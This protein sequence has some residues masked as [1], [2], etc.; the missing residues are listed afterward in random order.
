[1]SSQPIIRLK[2]VS[3][4]F[5]TDGGDPVEVLCDVDLEIHPGEKASLIGLSGSGK[6]TLL[7]I[8]AGLLRPDTGT[9]EFEGVQMSDLDETARARLRAERIGIALQSDN[10][11]PFLSA[12]ENVELALGFGSRL[13]RRQARLRALEL[14][15]RFGVAHRAD[16]RPRQ[17]AGGEAQRVALAVAM[18]N[19]PALLL[20]DEVVAQLDGE[21]A[22]HVVGEILAEDFALLYVSHDVALADRVE[23]RYRLH[24][25]RIE[26]R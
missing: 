16:H 6:S 11:I 19:G 20:A 4:A 26:A 15:E 25:H 12:R 10:L 3:K 22:G 2:G 8:I 1:L 17:L 21:T 18:A 24:D 23:R 13:G 7:S 5:P 14:L 9:L